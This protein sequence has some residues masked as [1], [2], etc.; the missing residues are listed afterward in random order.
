MV[1]GSVG[2]RNQDGKEMPE[3]VIDAVFFC[4][5][6]LDS[7][8]SYVILLAR[9]NRIK[10]V[11]KQLCYPKEVGLLACLPKLFPAS[12]VTKLPQD[13]NRPSVDSNLE[14]GSVVWY[15]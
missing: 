13:E 6:D 5:V 15:H 9:N 1:E 11:R 14:V 4:N 10:I 2:L 8:I 7:L 12:N 3:T